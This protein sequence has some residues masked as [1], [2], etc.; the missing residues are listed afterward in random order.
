LARQRTSHA[1]PP[2]RTLFTTRQTHAGNTI[3]ITPKTAPQP[4]VP[5]AAESARHLGQPVLAHTLQSA[6]ISLT[7]AHIDA[8]ARA[9]M[10]TSGMRAPLDPLST[11][12]ARRDN[13][14]LDVASQISVE[15]LPR[16]HAP[17]D[18]TGVFTLGA[19]ARDDIAAQLADAAYRRGVDL[20]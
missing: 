5:V 4:G 15:P 16:A 11:P 19:A 18:A 6:G 3:A 17:T 10:E 13:R 12:E 14:L 7:D 2:A 8:Q 1:V 20:S 9:G